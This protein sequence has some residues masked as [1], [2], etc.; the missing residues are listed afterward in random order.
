MIWIRR[1]LLTYVFLAVFVAATGFFGAAPPTPDAAAF[2]GLEIAHRG[3]AL[4]FPENTLAA[5]DGAHALGADAVEVDV[6]LSRDG[7]P[8]VIHD[9]TLERTTDGEGRVAE[10]TAAELQRLRVRTP[11]GAG[12]SDERIPTLEEVAERVVALDL[13]LEI[14]L[15]HEESRVYE[16]SRA[17]AELIARHGLH[18]RAF[19]SSF[20]P[21]FVYYVRD[22]DPRI[23]TALGLM[24]EPPYGAATEFLLRHDGAPRW[25]GTG[26]VEV[27]RSLATEEAL[28]RWRAQG[29]VVNVWTVNTEPAKARL[30][31]PGV[32]VTTDCP[33][34]SC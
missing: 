29:L 2:A 3:D 21:R 17:V 13:K 10:H 32:S 23:V 11:D 27:E 6:M 31:R 12:F 4:N 5:I 19:V 22:V 15:K 18:D 26:I 9:G 20:D 16:A 8:V 34:G 7:V 14:E 1:I 33:G 25:L 28:A 24:A 30:R